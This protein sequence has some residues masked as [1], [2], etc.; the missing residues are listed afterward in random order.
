MAG[1]FYNNTDSIKI[2]YPTG[3]LEPVV[4]EDLVFRPKLKSALPMGSQRMG[5]GIIRFPAYLSPA[6]N[7]GQVADNGTLPTAKDR[8]ERTF[9]LK[10]VAFAACFQIGWTMKAAVKAKGGFNGGEQAR[11]T[12]ETANNLG[13]FIE[14]TYVGTAGDGI[15]GY[16]ESDGSNSIKLK[17]PHGVTLVRD[18]HVISVRVS[19]GGGV[20]DSLDNRTVT[21]VD[22][23]NRDVYYNGADQTAV[24]NDPVY[25]VTEAAMVL[26]SVFA[27]GLRGLVDDGV[28]SQFIHGL[29]RTTTANIKLRSQVYDPGSLH[30]LTEQTLLIM[31]NNIRQYSNKRPETILCGPGQAMKYAEFVAPQRRFPTDGGPVKP[32]QGFKEEDLVFYAPGVALRFMISFDVIPRELYLLNWSTF[33]HYLAQEMDWMDEDSLLKA[34]PTSGGH[35]AS[36][37]AYMGSVENLGNFYPR[38]NGVIRNARDPLIGD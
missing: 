32:T 7:V 31:A 15:R 38:G 37:L 9:E 26:T 33:F 6:Q 1:E 11:R 21:S 17:L 5:E 14:Q 35:K 19:A 23:D 3:S 27:N 22:V 24:L 20:R 13:K 28:N 12:E 16:V 18:N 10:P 25:I 8:T 2:L 36:W 30:N 29:D 34:T 4:N